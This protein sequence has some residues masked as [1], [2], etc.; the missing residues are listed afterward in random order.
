[1]PGSQIS[2]PKIVF[3]RSERK[4][5]P[6]FLAVL[7]VTTPALGTLIWYK[8]TGRVA[9]LAITQEYQA[10]RGSLNDIA[11]IADVSWSDSDQRLTKEAFRTRLIRAFAAHGETVIVVFHDGGSGL[12]E[13][14]YRVGS[15]A[16]GP[17]PHSEAALGV[18]SS[19]SAYR[20]H[21]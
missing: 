16:F 3:R 7:F 6:L 9:P 18:R 2:S 8:F 10:R 4:Y 19:I 21:D 11:I 5:L 15:N 20:L 17:Y 14:T 12:N 1:M 13:V